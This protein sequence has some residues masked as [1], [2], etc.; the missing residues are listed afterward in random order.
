MNQQILTLEKHLSAQPGDIAA[1]L[2]MGFFQIYGE[3][4]AKGCEKLFSLLRFTGD[5][6]VKDL[7][8]HEL[9]QHP[10]IVDAE[11]ITIDRE[12][13]ENAIELI[14]RLRVQ[15]WIIEDIK[16]WLEQIRK[17]PSYGRLLNMG[18]LTKCLSGQHHKEIS[19]V[20]EL[21]SQLSSD[22]RIQRFS[23]LLIMRELLHKSTTI[24]NDEFTEDNAKKDLS[25][26]SISQAFNMATDSLHMDNIP[27][28]MAIISECLEKG[29]KLDQ[30][31]AFELIDRLEKIKTDN[32][33]FNM[34]R[35]YIYINTGRFSQ[36]KKEINRL[37]KLSDNDHLAAEALFLAA[38][39]ELRKGN[40]SKGTAF[41]FKALAIEESGPIMDNVADAL[42]AE[43]ERVVE[44][45]PYKSIV[46]Y[47][48]VADLCPEKAPPFLFAMAQVYIDNPM[49]FGK[50]NSLKKAVQILEKLDQ[51][52]P[53][54]QEATPARRRL[55]KLR[56][57]LGKM[58]QDRD[59]LWLYIVLLVGAVATIYHFI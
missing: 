18:L 42:M 7:I 28:Y 57:D 10:D 8:N 17:F 12:P 48:K 3:D 9:S 22:L 25:L 33:N 20:A 5:N 38:R 51:E 39:L 59:F 30:K 6:S 24:W 27:E 46:L 49:R 37:L 13:T 41:L 11:G 47:R 54:S 44:K 21:L 52:H 29:M 50:R 15:P 19:Q 34:K 1:G 45:R 43:G 16:P 31:F 58:P 36:A 4:K 55:E 53:N 35:I 14:L 56:D 26:K 40:F 32:L 23:K 2:M